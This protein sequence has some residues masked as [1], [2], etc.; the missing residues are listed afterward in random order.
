MVVVVTL[1]VDSS[2]FCFFFSFCSVPHWFSSLHIDSA[3]LTNIHRMEFDQTNFVFLFLVSFRSI[4]QTHVYQSINFSIK[5]SSLL[6]HVVGE[7]MHIKSVI[8]IM[9]K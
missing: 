9:I 1:F 7:F 2:D 5:Y 3:Q 8:N 4:G 6:S